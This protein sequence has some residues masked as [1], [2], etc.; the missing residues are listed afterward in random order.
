MVQGRQAR[1][2]DQAQV[3]G[4]L[5]LQIQVSVTFSSCLD[6]IPPEMILDLCR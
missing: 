2:G 6:T 4:P 1:G 3:V 5:R